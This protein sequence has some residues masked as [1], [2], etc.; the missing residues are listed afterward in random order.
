MTE[1]CLG[2]SLT[3]VPCLAG[4]IFKITHAYTHTQTHTC[5]PHNSIT[6][7]NHLYC[8]HVILPACAFFIWGC[9]SP[10]CHS[11]VQEIANL[12]WITWYYP[13]MMN[14][15]SWYLY[16]CI[17]KYQMLPEYKSWKCINEINSVFFIVF[18]QKTQNR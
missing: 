7:Q 10:F 13:Y 17:N 9:L 1:L 18:K 14:Y 2:A 3:R 8:N 12:N 16:W 6:K 5:S 4:Q 11:L 15:L